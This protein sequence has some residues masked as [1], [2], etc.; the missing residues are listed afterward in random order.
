[1]PFVAVPNLPGADSYA[2]EKEMRSRIGIYACLLAG[3]CGLTCSFLAADE[4]P[5]PRKS[6][7]IAQ[8]PM[9]S[10]DGKYVSIRDG[11]TLEERIL[12][13][14]SWQPV[15]V[16]PPE[17]SLQDHVVWAPRGARF[18]TCFWNRS[19]EKPQAEPEMVV[20][21]MTGK[22]LE[23]DLPHRRFGPWK[24]S[25]DGKQLL[26]TLLT[27]D[28][29]TDGRAGNVFAVVP[30]AKTK[31]TQV[32][33]CETVARDGFDWDADGESIWV[34]C[35]RHVPYDS[36]GGDGVWKIS[37][38]GS[39]GRRIVGLQY[40]QELT[41]SQDGKWLAVVAENNNLYVVDTKDGRPLELAHYHL[42]N[43]AQP[44]WAPDRGEL[45]YCWR[46]GLRLWHAS[47]PSEL[48]RPVPGSAGVRHPFWDPHD[49]S[50]WGVK[51]DV[52]LVRFDGARWE[53]KYT[54]S[55]APRA[56]AGDKANKQSQK[57]RG[58]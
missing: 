35:G 44:A 46:D 22:R 48:G 20:D 39:G 34:A 31:V 17:N 3:L 30:D 37:T 28:S 9:F 4:P 47:N 10:A 8:T 19:R 50:L 53:S 13:T 11:L 5:K 23:I 7:W 25:P 41:C 24:W 52:S 27:R 58:N 21:L 14:N 38:T 26:T 2:L 55:G 43:L 29:A 16:V 49:Q 42:G 51:D 36:D 32:S 12:E 33:H 15:T 6:P 54:L 45:A 1:M 57:A 18:V 40:V 56:P